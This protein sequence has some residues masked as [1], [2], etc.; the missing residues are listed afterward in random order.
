MTEQYFCKDCKHSFVKLT[1]RIVFSNTRFCRLSYKP[2]EIHIDPVYGKKLKNRDNYE[3]CAV[4]RL[5][6]SSCGTE[7]K[8]WQ[9]KHKK[10]L[11]KYMVKARE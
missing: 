10:D 3:Y 1:D 4:M 7:G 2:T 11:F 5:P 6:H 9:P 8:M